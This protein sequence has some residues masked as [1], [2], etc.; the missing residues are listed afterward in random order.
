MKRTLTINIQNKLWVW[1]QDRPRLNLSV[2]LK[3][4]RSGQKDWPNQA[5]TL[6][7]TCVCVCQHFVLRHWV[8]MSLHPPVL[9][10]LTPYLLSYSA[11]WHI[12]VTCLASEGIW[13]C[14]S[15]NKIY[16]NS[17]NCTKEALAESTRGQ[18]TR[19]YYLD[20]NIFWTKKKKA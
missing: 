1:P 11:L 18:H 12:Y 10:R 3:C 6:S 14:D 5:P 19:H 9:S 15:G 7:F 2:W 17:K 20:S 8:H 16:S 13:V 4:G